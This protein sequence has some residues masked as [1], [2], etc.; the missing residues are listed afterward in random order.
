MMSRM[1]F[2]QDPS[3][4]IFAD[5]LNLEKGYSYLDTIE[6][7]SIT[8]AD[9]EDLEDLLETGQIVR[10]G[11]MYRFADMDAIVRFCE[12]SY[13]DDPQVSKRGEVTAFN[14]YT[15]EIVQIGWTGGEV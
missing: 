10:T 3:D 14:P 6:K 13:L 12:A 5:E 8:M 11:T 4:P 7:E 15:Q 1:A 9:M 2:D